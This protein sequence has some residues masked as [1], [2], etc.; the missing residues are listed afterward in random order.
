VLRGELVRLPLAAGLALLGVAVA[1]PAVWP[2]QIGEYNRAA[3]SAQEAPSKPVLGALWD[4]YGLNLTERAE[5]AAGPRHFTATAWRFH[6]STGAFGAFEWQRPADA[7]PANL[8]DAGAQTRDG[9]LFVF[10]NFLFRIDGWKPKL[11]DL[12]EVLGH[13]P[14]LDRSGLPPLHLPAHGLVANS[15]RYVIGPV[16]LDQFEKGVEPAL[17]AFSLGAEVEIAQYDTVA[18]R[19]QLAVFSYPTPQIAIQRTR[20]FQKLAGAMA[21]RAGPM[22]AVILA[23]QDANA[24]ERLLALVKYN[25]VVTEDE[26]VPTRRDNVADLLLNIFLLTGLLVAICIVAGV[27]VGVLRRLGW[28]TSG[29]PMT[30]LHLEDRQGG[31]SQP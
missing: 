4:E 14:A 28:G 19:V 25:G 29:D 5:Y 20:E 27:V 17:A 7:K 26:R 13:L 24:A 9:A 11:D 22:V 18:G 6:D 12:A 31:P 10:G 1:R 16:G 3:P 21:K 8:A 15:E 2:D 23:P 30:L